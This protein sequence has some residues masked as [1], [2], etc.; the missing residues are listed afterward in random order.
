M[1]ICMYVYIVCL[2]KSM[3]HTCAERRTNSSAHYSTAFGVLRLL[4]V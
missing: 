4:Y 2:F 3:W 1:Y